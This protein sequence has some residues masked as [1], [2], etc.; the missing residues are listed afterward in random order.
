MTPARD[1]FDQTREIRVYEPPP[2]RKKGIWYL[3]TGLLLGLVIGLV[4]AWLVNPVVYTH[5]TPSG[6]QEDHRDT[7]RSMIAQ[8]YA[9]T[10]DLERAQLRLAVLEDDNPVYALGS[11]AQ[12]CMAEENPEEA[13]ALAL[14]ASALQSGAP[15][16][17]T[18]TTEPIPTQ[19]LDYTTPIP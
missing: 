15:A 11:Q 18:A 13:R 14:L 9:T 2:K 1:N 4:Y 8:A 12:R 7:Y 19:T 3:L 10:G 17:P 6:L 5:S 16:A